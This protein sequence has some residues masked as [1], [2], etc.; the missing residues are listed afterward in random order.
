MKK[1]LVLTT[2]T[3]TKSLHM[4]LLFWLFRA[5]LAIDSGVVIGYIGPVP[6]AFLLDLIWQH[7]VT[8]GRW[9]FTLPNV[10]LACIGGLLAGFTTGWIAGRLGKLLGAIA[11]F[12][13][14]LLFLTVIVIKNI[15]STE[16]F[17]QMYDTR[18]ALWVWIA[19]VP[20][21]VGGHFGALDGKRYFNQAALFCCIGFTWLAGMGFTLL[22]LYTAFITFEADGFIQAIINLSF[23]IFAELDWGWRSWKDSGHLL[24]HY[25]MLILLL[26]VFLIV[27]GIAGIVFVKTEKWIESKDAL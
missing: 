24:N 7:D 27:A 26:V 5:P 6:F 1:K 16:Y 2:W 25:T 22:H 8:G 9:P 10:L 3:P 15:D 18:P 4:T 17:E 19:I 20:G 23:P 21:I 12:F 13:P 14:L 11:V